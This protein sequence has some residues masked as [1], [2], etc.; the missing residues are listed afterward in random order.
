MDLDQYEAGMRLLLAQAAIDSSRWNLP[1][2]S[3]EHLLLPKSL[4]LHVLK[5]RV[6]HHFSLL[7]LAPL[8]SFQ[9]DHLLRQI[10]RENEHIRKKK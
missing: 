8:N 4:L 2:L 9:S 5:I 7:P 10:G 3:R 1:F 6:K